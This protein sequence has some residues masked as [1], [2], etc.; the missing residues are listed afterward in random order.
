MIGLLRPAAHVAP[1]PPDRVD[2]EY[3]RLRRRVF[4]GIFVGYAGYYLVRN[5]LALAIPDL[6]A[7]HPEY[8]KAEL[9]T[10][11][12]A[13]SIAYGLSKF[14]MG[15]VSDRSNPKYF[16]PLGL[17]LSS[18]LMAAFGLY[19]AFYGSL[20]A[21]I[22]VMAVNGWVQGMGW[23]PCGKSMVHWFSTRERGTVVSTW[24]VAHNIGGALVANL[25][26]VG[27]ILFQDWGAKF[28]FN[29]LIAALIALGVFFVLEDTP[30]SRGLPP[31]EKYKDDFPPGYSDAHEE[32]LPFREIFLKHV[33]PNRFL[34]AI[35][36][37]NAFCYFV[38][39]GVV[40]WIPTYLETAKGFSFQE[41]SIAW[42][43]YE[44]A[45]IP[46]TDCLRLALG[47]LVQGPARADDDDLHGAH[48]RRRRRLLDEPARPALDRLRSAVRDRLPHLR[49]DHDDRPAFAR[50]G[51]EESSRHGGGAHRA[52]RL[53][54]R[55]R[56][57]G[58]RRRL[59]RRSLGLG[60]RVRH[61]GGLLRARHRLRVA[62]APA[63]HLS[64]R[65][66]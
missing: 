25:A 28:Y 51:A 43:L 66:T 23:P 38:R 53:R 45:A 44:Y 14:L 11:L 6:L 40:N 36:V 52:L 63:P 58:H 13:L 26:L 17:L 32:T 7:E 30:Q 39:Y 46:G 16:L 21:I 10:A 31:V 48:A 15:S 62:D 19:E 65:P 1:L 35:A 9:G 37:A 59:D 34:W 22:V 55:F 12:T 47:P 29:A 54:V 60:R 50:P 57:R 33:L 4:A 3:R 5:N 2:P 61:H 20:A 56:D 27:V 49:A 8:S 64:Q 41:S 24:N 42:S 18:A